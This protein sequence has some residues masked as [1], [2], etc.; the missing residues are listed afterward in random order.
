MS[1]LHLFSSSFMVCG[2][3]CRP[4][5]HFEFLCMLL[6]STLLSRSYMEPS[7]FP[8]PNYLKRLPFLQCI[9]LPPLPQISYPKYLGGLSLDCLSCSTLYFFLYQ[10]HIDFITVA[11]YRWYSHKW[12]S[13]IPRAVFLWEVAGRF[14]REG[15]YVYLWLIHVDGWQKP[16]LI[17]VWGIFCVSI[18][19]LK[20]F[21]LV[22]WRVPLVI[23]RFRITKVTKWLQRRVPSCAE[24][25]MS[26]AG[27]CPRASAWLLVS[28]TIEGGHT[29]TLLGSRGMFFASN[30]VSSPRTKTGTS[31]LKLYCVEG[32]NLM[33]SGVIV[34][35]FVCFTT[36]FIFY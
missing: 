15:T 16:I 11:L 27:R 24:E 8:S 36:I 23:E 6:E 7:S 5:I 12:G 34:K 4:L 30:R 18:Q 33:C 2:L 35:S 29:D 22:L 9:F 17:W 13:Q 32:Q 31:P 14:N 21:V 25:A 19:I 10:D 26:Q 1:V 3:T 28:V 20:C